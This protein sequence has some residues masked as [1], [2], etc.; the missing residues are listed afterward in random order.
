MLEIAWSRGRAA[1]GAWSASPGIVSHLVRLPPGEELPARIAALTG[2][3]RRDLARALPR[4]EVW[5]R[6][7]QEV[8]D[9][10]GAGSRA[11]ATGELALG[12]VHFARFERAFLDDWQRAARGGPAEVERGSGLL[13]LLCTHEIACRLLPGLPRRGLRA[14]AGH[15]GHVMPEEKRAGSHVRATVAVWCALAAKLQAAGVTT[16]ADL[17]RWLREVRPVRRGGREFSLPREER[18]RLPDAPGV[19]RLQGQGGEVLY[20]GKASSLRRRVNSYFQHRHR[21][22]GGDRT[23]EMLTQVW[24]VDVTPCASSLEAAVREADEIKEHAPPYNVALRGR[25]TAAFF[26]RPDLGSVRPAPDDAHR[27]GPLPRRDS[28]AALAAQRRLLAKGVAPRVGPAGN[29]VW[30]AALGLGGRVPG[31][32]ELL[33][34]RRLD[35]T[36]LREGFA[37]FRARVGWAEGTDV[38]LPEMLR[39]GGWLWREHLAQRRDEAPEDPTNDPPGGA[40]PLWDDEERP[41]DPEDVARWFALALGRCAQLV[42]RARWFERL[43]ESSLWWQPPDGEVRR[44][45]VERG[46]VKLCTFVANRV[47]D[48]SPTARTPVPHG[49]SLSAHER[50]RCCNAATYDRLRVLTTELRRLVAA[51][52]EIELCLGPG[53]VL[54]RAALARR[55]LGV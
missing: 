10:A 55:L 50:R 18:L 25:E 34:R 31:E 51:R 52:A 11:A 49:A 24:G 30:M 28:L 3:S 17:R 16:L 13:E 2:V 12:V 5:R 1:D 8:R 42:R 9:L 36:G 35:P 6:L 4:E 44:L 19:Y 22:P 15:L 29:G 33:D 32:N 38:L 45:V 21:R 40:G 14:V 54:D 48:R 39:A 53:L 46:E 27:V 41:R 47:V 37:L 23:L 26:A 20:V 43:C 7:R